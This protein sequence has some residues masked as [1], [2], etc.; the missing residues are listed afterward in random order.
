M[1]KQA[2]FAI[3]EGLIIIVVLAVLAGGGYEVW[4]KHHTTTVSTTNAKL[5]YSSPPI[6]TTAA[7]SVNNSTGLNNALNTLNQTNV[8]AS[9]TDSTQLNSQATGL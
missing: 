4:H 5:N 1:N 2:G 8:N 9:S 3:V 7:P 6:I